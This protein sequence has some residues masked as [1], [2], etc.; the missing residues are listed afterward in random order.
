MVSGNK[1]LIFAYSVM[2]LMITMYY[3]VPYSETIRWF[4]EKL[5]TKLT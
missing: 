2:Y 3:I 4:Q 1:L 5:F